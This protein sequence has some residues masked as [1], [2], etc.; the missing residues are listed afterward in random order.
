MFIHIY[1]YIQHHEIRLFFWKKIQPIILRFWKQTNFPLPTFAFQA[2]G[3]LSQAAGTKM[4]EVEVD[5][6]GCKHFRFAFQNFF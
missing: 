6:V 1:I 4:L 2:M 3:A 5:L